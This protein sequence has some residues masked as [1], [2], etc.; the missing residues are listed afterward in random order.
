[1]DHLSAAMLTISHMNNTSYSS[2]A[3][4]VT[5]A[6]STLNEIKQVPSAFTVSKLLGLKEHYVKDLIVSGVRHG[7]IYN[8]DG[9]LSLTSKGKNFI[10]Q[11]NQVFYD[12]L[13][14]I[15]RHK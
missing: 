9:I 1:M 14:E 8:A 12:Y 15:R 13:E 2:G 11:S 6:V 10:A 3:V 4:K 7:L 5:I